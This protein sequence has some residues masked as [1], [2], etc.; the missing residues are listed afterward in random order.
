MMN[1]SHFYVKTARRR[2]FV[3]SFCEDQGINQEKNKKTRNLRH[4]QQSPLHTHISTIKLLFR[5]RK[6]D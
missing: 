1:L 6:Y 3:V 4:H 2:D 5:S